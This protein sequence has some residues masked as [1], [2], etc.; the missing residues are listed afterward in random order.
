MKYWEA[1][2][3]IS[4]HIIRCKNV[5]TGSGGWYPNNIDL[6]VKFAI[7]HQTVY[8]R[9]VLNGSVLSQVLEN[10]SKPKG[11]SSNKIL[12][13]IYIENST[14]YY[15]YSRP[16]W[17]SAHLTSREYISLRHINDWLPNIYTILLD[18]VRRIDLCR[19]WPPQIPMQSSLLLCLKVGKL[20]ISALT[21]NVL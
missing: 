12:G 2:L 4:K 17:S 7:W 1:F 14:R 8:S 18:H 10:T 15:Q 21:R 6:F 3:D 13:K 20:P 11:R 19:R 5:K 9:N 16:Q